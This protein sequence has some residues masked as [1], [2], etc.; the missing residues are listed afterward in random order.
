[1]TQSSMLFTPKEVASKLQL[2]LLTI[3][4]YI[5]TKKLPAI[6]LG[7]SYRILEQDLTDFIKEHKTYTP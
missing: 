3:Y 6:K 2:N 4:R 7:R 1:M 5:K